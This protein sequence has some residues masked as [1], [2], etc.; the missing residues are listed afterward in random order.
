MVTDRSAE[1][2]TGVSE[3]LELLDGS[4]SGVVE[5]I[6]AVLRIVP[7]AALFT[8]PCISMVAKACDATVFKAR[9]PGHCVQ[10]VPPSSEYRT[11]D[12]RDGTVSARTTAWASEGP[13]LD[14][15]MV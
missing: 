6:I 10:V 12:S 8:V 3:V 9:V 14:T 5:V 7:V 4:G 1:V 11:L 2:S 13:A 15:T